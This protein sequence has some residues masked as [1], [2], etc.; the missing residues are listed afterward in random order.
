MWPQFTCPLCAQTWAGWGTQEG[1][2]E[3]E[4]EWEW[5]HAPPLASVGC[6]EGGGHNTCCLHV[7]YPCIYC[8]YSQIG[9]KKKEGQKSEF[10][11]ELGESGPVHGKDVLFG[12]TVLRLRLSCVSN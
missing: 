4:W 7:I 9:D 12:C 2:R 5:G 8:I 3:W 6:A 11:A 10:E 1:G